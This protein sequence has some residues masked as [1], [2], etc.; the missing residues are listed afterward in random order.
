MKEKKLY[1]S[2][3]NAEL[4]RSAIETAEGKASAR[5]L[6]VDDL[7]SKLAEAEKMLMSPSKRALAGT[8]VRIHSSTEKLPSAYRYRADST[9]AVC[10]H[11]GKGWVLVE[12]VRDRLRQSAAYKRG[13]EIEPSDSARDHI[14]ATLAF[15]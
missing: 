1:V 9:Q 13:L 14:L 8:R 10:E 2:E 5:T 11:D 6:T 12:V 4:V 3:E 15:C 7:A